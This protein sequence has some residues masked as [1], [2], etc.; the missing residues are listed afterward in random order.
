[1]TPD[2]QKKFDEMN[3]Q[4][5]VSAR[6]IKKEWPGIKVYMPWGLPLF[7]VPF[8][9]HSP[10]ATALMDGPVLDMVPFMRLPEAQLHQVTQH[11]QLWQLK[12]EWET[13]GKIWPKTMAMEGPVVSR[14]AP[15]S[16]TEQ[17]EANNT[18]RSLLNIAGY[19]ANRLF[20]WPTPFE[21]ADYWGEQQYGG[22]AIK[23]TPV[24]TPKPLYV[25]YATMTRNLNRANFVKWLPTGSAT[26]FAM[27]FEYYKTKELIHVFW[28]IRG[29]RPVTLKLQGNQK[30]EV[31]DEMDNLADVTRNANG[32]TFSVS[33]TPVYVRGLKSTPAIALGTPDHS[34]AK[35]AKESTRLANLGDGSW[36]LSSQ[37]DE[38]TKRAMMNSLFASPAR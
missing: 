2:E 29:K 8:L 33:S 27:Q 3:Q 13:A 7:P 30:V 11:S 32:S 35:P 26:V 28:T 12:Q 1:M 21:C 15:G 6:A 17:Q 23:R 14:T 25:S 10:E 16:V 18:I 22:G 9:R 4:F 38:D 24:L 19:G 5:I 37:R 34:D 20:G 36:K 31:F